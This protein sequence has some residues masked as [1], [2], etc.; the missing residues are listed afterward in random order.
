V[1]HIDLPHVVA[2][3]VLVM[4]TCRAMNR[5]L[6]KLGFIEPSTLGVVAFPL[7]DSTWGRRIVISEFRRRF[8]LLCGESGTSAAGFRASTI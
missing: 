8:E 1:P 5:G 4:S 6:L 2:L 7:E 3:H